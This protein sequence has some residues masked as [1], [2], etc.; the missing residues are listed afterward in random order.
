[1]ISYC[2]DRIES[3]NQSQ[4]YSQEVIYPC[5]LDFTYMTGNYIVSQCIFNH[6]I[7]QTIFENMV[8]DFVIVKSEKQE[9][10]VDYMIPSESRNPTTIH[11][12]ITK[13][14]KKHI[15]KSDIINIIQNKYLLQKSKAKE[16][17][18]TWYHLYETHKLSTKDIRTCSLLLTPYIDDISIQVIDIQSYS[19]LI[20]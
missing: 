1:M 11:S 6:K 19:Q 13:L 3:I 10:H 17:Y 4:Q 5:S 16:E 20:F 8:S 15:D 18:E 2:N 9:L 14:Y 12:Y 7:L